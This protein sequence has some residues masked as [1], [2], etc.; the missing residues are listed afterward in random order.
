ML[1]GRAALPLEAIKRRHA[2]AVDEAPGLPARLELDFLRH[3]AYLEAGVQTDRQWRLA[4]GVAIGCALKLMA[5][6]VDM[7]HVRYD[8]EGFRRHLRLR[9]L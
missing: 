5:R 6:Y 4:I 3:Y 1:S 9:A 7:R 2:H 8:D